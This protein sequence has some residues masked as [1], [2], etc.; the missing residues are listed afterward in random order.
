MNQFEGY[1]GLEL[2]ANVTMIIYLS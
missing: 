1:R 2:M